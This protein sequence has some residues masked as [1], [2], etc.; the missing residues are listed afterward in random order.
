MLDIFI[1]LS[2]VILLALGIAV[3]MRVLKQPLIIGY[4]ITGIIIT[5][6]TLNGS[7]LNSIIKNNQIILSFSQFGVAFLLFIVGMHLNPRVIREVGFTSLIVGFIQIAITG[8]GAFFIAGLLGFSNMA[9][10]Y[11]AFA[12]TFSSTIIITKILSDKQDLDSLYG[13]ITVGVLI[14]QD[15]VVI[16]LLIFLNYFSTGGMA[17]V[18]S[19]NIFYAVITIIGLFFASVCILPKITKFIAENQE[20]LFLFAIGWC[21]LIASLFDKLG[22]GM[23][24]GALLAGMALSV[25]PYHIEI[26]SKIRPLRDFFLILFFILLG[27]EITLDSLSKMINIAL[28][29]SGFVILIK[30]LTIVISLGALGYSR[31][32]SFFSGISLGQISEFSFILAALGVTLGH[33]NQEVSS[34]LV[35]VGL[36]T[37]ASSTYL[38][39]FSSKLYAVLSKPLSIFERS[40]VRDR[41][42]LRQNYDIILFGYNRIGFSILQS[43][44]RSK[45]KY[46]V[47]DYN[48]ETVKKLTK[49][50]IRCI[51]GDAEDA[52]FLQDIKLAQADLVISTIPDKEVNLL[53]LN[54]IRRTNEHSVVILTAHQI[55]DAFDLYED[56]ADYVILPHFL[57]GE[58]TAALI[59]HAKTSK[60]R[61]REEKRKQIESLEKRKLNGHEHPSILRDHN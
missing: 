54:K 8:V 12:L 43:L 60:M 16:G 29:F 26:S 6:I 59:E 14:L 41:E 40:N 22:F 46:L 36:I 33:I 5:F 31:R 55:R 21:F 61:Y 57:G 56:G 15:L 44:V 10:F 23:E 18:S 38:M 58:Y 49:Q 51:Y 52:E 34:L 20:I 3:I 48:P 9:S 2:I 4:I 1:Y 50:G 11:I 28:I 37:I 7:S 17:E 30:F 39:K 47:V 53:L 25:S 42:K 45:K 35:M 19:S 32:T 13:K 27:L 24:I